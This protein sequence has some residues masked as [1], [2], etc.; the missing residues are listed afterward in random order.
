MCCCGG[1]LTYVENS[2]SYDC[3][4]LLLLVVVVVVVVLVVVVHFTA[5]DEQ[6]NMQVKL[7]L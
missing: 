5:H 4:L 6:T 3:F 1:T 7:Y 2:I